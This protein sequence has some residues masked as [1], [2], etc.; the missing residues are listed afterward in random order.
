MIMF[1]EVKHGFPPFFF[2][3]LPMFTLRLI[4]KQLSGYS[5]PV[6]TLVRLFRPLGQN[7]FKSSGGRLGLV[8]LGVQFQL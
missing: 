5:I 7:S 3:S 8:D 6:E 4:L 1:L 2:A